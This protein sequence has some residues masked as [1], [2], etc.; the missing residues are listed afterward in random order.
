[1][2]LPAGTRLGSYEI[3]V[4]I[5]TGGMGEVYKC[6]DTR[7]DRLVAVKVL[8]SKTVA[9]PERKRRF[10]QEAKTASALNHPGIVTI[11]DIADADGI[12]FIAMEYVSG[13]T[14]REL[15]GRKGLSLKDTL[16]YS[17]QAASALAKA[18]AAGIVHRDLKP[19][20]IMATA[21][22]QVKILDFGLAKLTA[23]PDDGSVSGAETRTIDDPLKTTPGTII[24]TVAYMSPEQAEG[25][26]VDARSDIF[27]FG[28]VLYEMT[29]GA[30][31]FE[32]PTSTRTLAAVVGEDPVSPTQLTKD[33]P[34]EL[35][36][37]IVRCLRKDP[38]RRFQHV[39]DVAV[40]L[41]EVKT[42]S[43]TRQTGTGDLPLRRRVRWLLPA[44][45]VGLIV[46]AFAAWFV[47]QRVNVLL[48]RAFP[49]PL[50]ALRGDER[51]PSLSPDGSQVAFSWNGEDGANE[52][53]YVMPVGTMTPLRLTSDPMPDQAPAWSPDGHLIAFVRIDGNSRGIYLVTPPVPNSEKKI[54]DVRRLVTTADTTLSWSPDSTL[55]FV[56]EGGTEQTTILAIH[57]DRSPPRVVLS[58]P[59]A[60]GSLSYPALSTT[61][62]QLAYSVCTAIFACD[63]YV[64]DL[65]ADFVAKGTPRPLTRGNSEVRGITWTA[66][67]NA[68]ICGLGALWV[69][70]LQRISTTGAVSQPVDLAATRA[71]YPSVSR[72]GEKLAYE[73]VDQ[74][75][76]L[77]KLEPGKPPI[78]LPLSSTLDD[79]NPQLSPDGTKLVFESRRYGKESQLFVGNVDGTNAVPL[80]D[81]ST[82]IQGSPF[83]SQPDGNHIVFDGNVGQGAF[84]LMIVDA[85]GSPATTLTRTGSIPSWSRDGKWIYYGDGRIWRIGS[86]GGR[87]SPFSD[88]PGSN[89]V[90]SPNGTTLY[91][92][93][94]NGVMAKSTSGGP[95]HRVLEFIGREPSVYTAHRWFPSD[96]GIYY[97]TRPDEAHHYQLELRLKNVH[98][99]QDTTVAP[100]EGRDTAGLT[101]SR[102]GKMIL[103]SGSTPS[104][105]SD[106]MLIRNFR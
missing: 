65:G 54:A 4:L 5:G 27:S 6:R 88:N 101:V 14:L 85:G 93:S 30:R 96:E 38:A 67:G 53:I 77:W 56:A 81:G 17:I 46:I 43:G 37:I 100:F 84:G 32:R 20:N 7:L 80:T 11:Y 33:L 76:D 16:H 26:E 3:L 75:R 68:L 62:R 83:W 21:D 40:E 44:I 95:E 74:D 25:K 52:D 24:G 66:D 29:T 87:P 72:S 61:G 41:E 105:G 2:P 35:E 71:I 42:E 51:M 45:G 47:S 79:R 59:I 104:Q 28:A 13:K 10:V 102:D 106:L 99:G 94:G 36:R 90:E 89:P 48:P 22:G 8:P 57:V 103:Y 92:T 50:T 18:H 82:G 91:F 55:L 70:S 78:R 9:D 64:T 19:S 39:G 60:S 12:P 69:F 34:H 49:E 97:L 1:M 58:R 63:V 23:P 98:T 73:R 31:A 86:T 15:I